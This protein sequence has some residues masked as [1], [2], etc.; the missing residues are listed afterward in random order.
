[1]HSY[2]LF[3]GLLGEDYIGVD[4]KEE[5]CEHRNS[6]LPCSAWETS[7]LCS[8]PFQKGYDR[9]TTDDHLILKK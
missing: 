8:T 6:I 1:M 4:V 2:I 5:E 7:F 3:L 9:A